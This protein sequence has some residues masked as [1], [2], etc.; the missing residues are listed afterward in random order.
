MQN[1]EYII[2]NE[3]INNE[4]NIAVCSNMLIDKNMPDKQLIQVL[5]TLSEMEPTHIVIPCNLYNEVTTSFDSSKVK[6]FIDNVTDIATTIMVKSNGDNPENSNIHLVSTNDIFQDSQ[7]NIMGIP[8]PSNF[9]K[10]SREEKINY[11]FYYARLS[12]CE[13]YKRFNILLFK[14]PIVAEAF[15]QFEEISL[16]HFPFD[17]IIS[18]PKT[19]N[20]SFLSHLLDSIDYNKTHDKK[21]FYKTAY[22]CNILISS[23]INQINNITQELFDNEYNGSIENVRVLKR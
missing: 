21:E 15:N 23:G 10:L 17:L 3:K 9:N 6:Y 2:N 5:D 22:N 19:E 18:G 13:A 20:K 1:K 7:I 16:E 11:L 4:L 14:D 8:E 12:N